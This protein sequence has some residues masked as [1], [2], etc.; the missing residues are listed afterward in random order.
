MLSNPVNTIPWTYHR[1]RISKMYSNMYKYIYRLATRVCVLY[2]CICSVIFNIFL[3]TRFFFR[4]VVS[5]SFFL[6]N[7]CELISCSLYFIFYIFR[8]EMANGRGLQRVYRKREID[9]DY[10]VLI[11]NK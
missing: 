2:M 5:F 3:S 11:V 8:V 7:Q 9:D 6:F 4:F 1:F 10:I